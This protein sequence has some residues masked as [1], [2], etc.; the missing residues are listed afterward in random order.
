MEEEKR[1]TRILI[2]IALIFCA[3]LIGY[4]AFYVP[5]ASLENLVSTDMTE[6]LTASEAATSPS[7]VDLNA[8]T[9]EDLDGLEGIGPV[10]AQRIIDYRKEYGGFTNIEELKKV[11]GIGEA[12]FQKLHDKIMVKISPYETERDDGQ[13]K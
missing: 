13:T 12:L 1:Q 10:L 4:N 2:S 11:K 8:A 9:L 3:L 7:K 5:D 6:S